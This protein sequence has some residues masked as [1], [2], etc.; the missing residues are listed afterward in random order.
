MWKLIKITVTS[1]RAAP[2]NTAVSG[3]C[4]FFLLRK[5]RIF[6]GVLRNNRVRW[7]VVWTLAILSHGQNLSFV[8]SFLV[9][10]ET[11]QESLRSQELKNSSN[12]FFFLTELVFWTCLKSGVPHLGPYI[13]IFHFWYSIQQMFITGS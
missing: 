10:E 13:D 5:T 12:R 6:R 11:C 9:E 2:S 3:Q 4:V 8:T 7:L 1:F